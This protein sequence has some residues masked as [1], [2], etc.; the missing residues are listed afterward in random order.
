MMPPL[1]HCVAAPIAADRRQMMGKPQ[2]PAPTQADLAQKAADLKNAAE[3]AQ[4]PD[5]EQTANPG[6]VNTGRGG[7]SAGAFEAEGQRPVLERSRKVR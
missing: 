1:S 7:N 2:K 5:P 3:P 4:R 6:M